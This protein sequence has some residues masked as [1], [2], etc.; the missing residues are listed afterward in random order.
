MIPR[1]KNLKQISNDLR[2]NA[3]KQE[4]H[5]WYDFLRNYPLQFYRQ[6][7]IGPYIVDFYCPKAKLIIELDGMQHYEKD[8]IVYDNNR[9]KAFE[10]LNL[11]V[12]RFSNYEIDNNFESVCEKI[13]KKVT[14]LMIK[15]KTDK[16]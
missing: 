8:A 4:N 1:N 15:E 11:C 10:E 16:E 3:T 9:T 13:N 12:I 14:E 7:I 6:K 5:L 2:N